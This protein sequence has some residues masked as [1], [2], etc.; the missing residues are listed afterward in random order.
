M[1]SAVR[2]TRQRDAP[3]SRRCASRVPFFYAFSYAMQPHFAEALRSWLQQD[4]FP[5]RLKELRRVFLN[6]HSYVFSSLRVFHFRMPCF[7]R[8]FSRSA[9][10]LFPT[11]VWFQVDLLLHHDGTPFF[12]LLESSDP[13]A[14]SPVCLRVAG[15]GGRRLF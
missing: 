14:A 13:S 7:H 12:E 10:I 6:P 3:T 1:G 15:F 11:D 5:P 2:H 8:I 9:R 4:S